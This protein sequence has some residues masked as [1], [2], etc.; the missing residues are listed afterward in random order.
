MRLV[1]FQLDFVIVILQ[2]NTYTGK[3]GRRTY[4]LLGCE[5]N[6]K[7]RTYK[8]D[9]ARIISE[10][11]KCGCPFR[12]K[13]EFVN[14]GDDWITS[15]VCGSHNHSFALSLEGHPYADLLNE[16]K[17]SMLSDM[18]KSMMKSKNILLTL[19]EHNE[20]NV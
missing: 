7:Y 19:K 3:K 2:S 8:K 12:F 13:G 18:T 10:T 1:A 17:K 11:R 15:T 20:K 4:V 9:Y 6:G 5:R 16:N 14:N